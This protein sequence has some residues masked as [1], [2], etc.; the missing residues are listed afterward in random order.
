MAIYYSRE[1]FKIVTNDQI[2]CNLVLI[3]FVIQIHCKSKL[4]K[5]STL[6]ILMIGQNS[7]TLK[8]G[9]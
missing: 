7:H 3:Y 6:Y 2:D 5:Y 1:G 9:K 4:Y 8:I